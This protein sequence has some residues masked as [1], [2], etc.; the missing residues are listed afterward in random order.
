MNFQ[1][2]LS[3]SISFKHKKPVTPTINK[4]NASMKSVSASNRND[5]R[6]N[7]VFTL[8]EKMR[9]EQS[10]KRRTPHIESN[11]RQVL[12]T[13]NQG[14]S[15]NLTMKNK[16]TLMNDYMRMIDKR[17]QII[18]DIKMKQGYLTTQSY[19]TTMRTTK[20]NISKKEYKP[21]IK[22]QNNH[23]EKY[24]RKD[25]LTVRNKYHIYYSKMLNKLHSNESKKNELKKNKLEICTNEEIAEIER[26]VNTTVGNERKDFNSFTKTTIG[27][28]KKA[29]RENDLRKMLL[30]TEEISKNTSKVIQP[31]EKN[32]TEDIMSRMKVIDHNDDY[33][34][35]NRDM[36]DEYEME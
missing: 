24:N 3:S 14:N 20:S 10:E 18:K 6:H 16:H 17:N 5:K 31:S 15:K 8:I 22:S 30:Y 9:I 25:V 26:G 32:S 1:R 2:P 29:K 35:Y 11:S 7:E 36:E 12:S 33:D 27:S 13:N 19:N 23:Y 34:D 4:N 28:D 21:L